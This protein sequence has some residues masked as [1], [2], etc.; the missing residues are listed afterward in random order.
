ML[1]KERN[2]KKKVSQCEVYGHKDTKIRNLWKR[3][4]ERDTCV[5]HIGTK[6]QD[7]R[8]KK[9]TDNLNYK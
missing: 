1:L 3:G 9:D 7:N 4:R 5:K 2:R 8:R 6:N